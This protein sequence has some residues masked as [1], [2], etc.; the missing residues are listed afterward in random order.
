MSE[1]ESTLTVFVPGRPRT[2]GSLKPVAN[3]ATQQ[4]HMEEQVG[5]SKAWRR[6]VANEVIK[7]I[8]VKDGNGKYR[9]RN[10]YPITAPVIVNLLF[11]FSR[12]HV[13]WTESP[14]GWP[15]EIYYGDIDKLTRNVLDALTDARLYRDDSLVIEVVS[16]KRFAVGSEAAGVL[17][18]VTKVRSGDAS[19]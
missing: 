14:D 8:A 13:Q 10:D 15:T 6:H 9:L 1:Q 5:Q 7:H 19:D 3:W 17:I 11:I 16:R 4:V 2:K 18:Q 12:E